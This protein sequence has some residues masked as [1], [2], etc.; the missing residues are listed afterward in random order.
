MTAAGAGTWLDRL[1]RAGERFGE[2]ELV[3]HDLPAL[4]VPSG[5]I[6]VGDPVAAEGQAL[7]RR[8]APGAYPVALSVAH[9]GH[10]H[11]VA[12]AVVRLAERPVARWEAALADDGAA[13]AV[14]ATAAAAAFVDAAAF[15]AIVDERPGF[16]T[17]SYRALERQLLTEHYAPAWGWAAY[18]PTST[19]GNCVAFACD[20]GGPDAP[21][22]WGLDEAGA[23]VA[24]VLDLQLDLRLDLQRA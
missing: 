10:E 4:Q 23:A 5:Q 11:R 9:I 14:T 8:V 2:I 6:V 20:A 3:V 13:A 18:Q 19:T 15:R 12:A 17:P 21:A 16:P 7:A 24:L 22:W 1:L